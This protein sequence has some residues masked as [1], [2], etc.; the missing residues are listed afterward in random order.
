MKKIWDRLG[1]TFSSACIIHCILVAFVPLLFPSIA[2]Y[3]HGNRIHLLIGGIVLITSLFA[4]IP[5]LKKHGVTWIIKSAVTGLFLI[6]LSLI[7]EPYS[8]EK[9]AHTLSIMGSLLLVFAHIKN[10]H[11][12]QL[13][14][15]R[16]C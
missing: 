14:K 9:I 3:A 1:I 2:H 8:S 11:H 4:F 7:V 16:C 5:G 12:S 6:L 13:H 15:Y 10:I